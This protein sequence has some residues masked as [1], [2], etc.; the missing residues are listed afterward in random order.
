MAITRVTG[1]QTLTTYAGSASPSGDWESYALQRLDDGRMAAV[2]KSVA[3]SVATLNVSAL[4]A[5]GVTHSAI[6]TLESASTS[7]QLQLP[8]IASNRTSGFFVA[9]EDDATASTANSGNTFGQAFTSTGAP[10]TARNHLTQSS[11]G[12][13]YTA[14]VTTLANGNYITAWSDTLT[15]SGMPPSS[16]IMARLYSASGVALG[17]EFRL[18]TTTAGVQLGTDLTTL[19][20]GR[21]VA[22]W[23]NAA[24]SGFTLNSTELRGRFISATGAGTGVD[25]Q[26]DTIASGGSYQDESLEILSLA[27][28]GFAVVWEEEN[29]ASTESIHIQRF[30]AA[31]VKSGAELIAETATGA[32]NITQMIT[33]ETA[34]G[35]FAVAW[36]LFNA[37][38]NL[39]TSHVRTFSYTG[40]EIGTE[41]SLTKIGAPGLAA[42]ADLELMSNGHVMAIGVNGKSIATQVFD[43]GDERLIGTAAADTLYGKHGV[44]DQIFGQAGNDVIKALGGN[45]FI[46]GGLGNDTLAGGAGFDNFVFD[47]ALSAT[48]NKDTITDFSVAADTIRIDNAIFT[49]FGAAVGAIAAGQFVIGTAALD[50]DD[51]IIYNSATGALTY[52]SN[53]NLAGGAVQFATLALNLALTNADIV[54]F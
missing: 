24:L 25:F 14:S 47:T 9:W 33:T 53:G 39:S 11:A 21:A 15:A 2:W 45:D 6:T 26:I 12:G 8:S 36:R 31:G 46:R 10:Q 5:L 50:G 42:A 34:N 38:A 30:T 43:F 22:V 35:G 19:G 32:T 28:G 29:T 51:F 41:S 27:N 44:N 48:A 17:N 16:E 52:D 54:V 1:V 23:G 37:P 18:N 20:D 49:A 3:G 7:R 4:D 40:T 13:E